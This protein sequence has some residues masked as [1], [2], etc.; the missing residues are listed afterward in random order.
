MQEDIL[1]ED[2][3]IQEK[4]DLFF[5]I[6]V[7]KTKLLKALSHVHN[8]VEKKT[9]IAVLSHVKFDANSENLTISA[10]DMDIAVVET[11]EASVQKQESLT[12]PAHKLFEVIRKLPDDSVINLSCQTSNTSQ[13]HIKAGMSKFILN[14]LPATEFP[15]FEQEKFDQS[16]K[17]PTKDLKNILTKTK[18]A[19]SNEEMRYYLNGLYFEFS[20]QE[21]E[22]ILSVVGT[23]CHRLALSQVKAPKEAKSLA[24]VIIPKKT[25]SELCRLLDDADEEVTI[26]MHKNKIR[27]DLKNVTLISKL[28]DGTFPSYSKAIPTNNDKVMQVNTDDITKAVDRVST[29][30]TDKFNT[31]KFLAKDGRLE[32][33][34]FGDASGFGSD[35]INVEYDNEP[36]EMGFNFKYLLEMFATISGQT[37]EFHFADSFSPSIVKDSEDENV[38]FVIMPMRF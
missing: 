30:S 7:E 12:L 21:G 6:N 15:S 38:T 28:I 17:F 9:T 5:E 34:A 1:I 11:V 25:I 4:S 35:I 37:M 2:A 23:D 36:I 14:S 27:F 16:F 32:I 13:V 31:I 18:F 29:M 22:V 33:S 8:I 19:M 3:E 24:P 26:S 10:T 20:E